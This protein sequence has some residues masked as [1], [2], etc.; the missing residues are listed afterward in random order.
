M[1]EKLTK[2]GKSEGNSAKTSK[3]GVKVM[4]KDK[5]AGKSGVINDVTDETRKKTR[6]LN[7][8]KTPTKASGNGSDKMKKRGSADKVLLR[9]AKELKLVTKRLNAKSTSKSGIGAL[10][11][12]GK[13]GG[14]K[15]TVRD[16][17]I[18][19]FSPHS[20][21]GYGWQHAGAYVHCSK[22]SKSDPNLDKAFRKA[23]KDKKS[24]TDWARELGFTARTSEKAT[25]IPVVD[26]IKKL[27]A[28]LKALKAAKKQVIKRA[29]TKKAAKKNIKVSKKGVSAINKV[30]ATTT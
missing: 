26:Q 18:V 7:R 2:N 23:L 22:L 14:V 10:Q 1:S 3:K 12:Y 28:D 21:L 17:D 29:S 11:C 4:K 9:V 30:A 20:F 13:S 25:P 19:V 27:E 8:V 6:A 16:H 15:V 24:G 5:K